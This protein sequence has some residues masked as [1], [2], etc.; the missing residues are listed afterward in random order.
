MQDI[1]LVTATDTFAANDVVT[2]SIN[3][4]AGTGA[5]SLLELYNCALSYTADM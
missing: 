4:A 2:L 3:R 1:S 5:G